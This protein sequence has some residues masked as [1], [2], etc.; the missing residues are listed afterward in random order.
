MTPPESPYNTPYSTPPRC[1]SHPQLRRHSGNVLPSSVAATPEPGG[2]TLN[3][4]SGDSVRT[5]TTLNSSIQDPPMDVHTAAVAAAH[6]CAVAATEEVIHFKIQVRETLPRVFLSKHQAHLSP[7]LRW[8]KCDS[9]AC[10]GGTRLSLWLMRVYG[11]TK[12]SPWPRSVKSRWLPASAYLII[13][14]GIHL[15]TLTT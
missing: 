14:W 1:R 10:N 13:S 11:G 8:R 7:G 12:L 6:C 9:S 3:T 2:F 4:S 15:L 5:S